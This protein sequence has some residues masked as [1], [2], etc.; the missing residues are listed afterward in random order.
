[1]V[2]RNDTHVNKRVQCEL[3]VKYFQLPLRR[4]RTTSVSDNFRDARRFVDAAGAGSE[5]SQ[6]CTFSGMS[7]SP[8]GAVR[9]HELARVPMCWYIKFMCTK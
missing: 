1:M 7:V 2:C 4:W 9:E 5:Y 3:T 8:A 6:A